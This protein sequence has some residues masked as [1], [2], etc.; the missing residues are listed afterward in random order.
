MGFGS[1]QEHGSLSGSGGG[2]GGGGGPSGTAWLICRSALQHHAG[3]E[4]GMVFGRGVSGLEKRVRC[5][6]AQARKLQQ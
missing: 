1:V 2:G 4:A 6:A 3:I 5:H